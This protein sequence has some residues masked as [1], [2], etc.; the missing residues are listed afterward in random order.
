M[1][2]STLYW[3]M[4]MVGYCSPTLACEIRG[5]SLMSS[6]T[7]AVVT[8]ETES[9]DIEITVDLLHAPRTGCNFLKYVTAGTYDGG[10]FGRT[11]RPDNQQTTEVPISVIQGY[12]NAK[13]NPDGFG[14]LALE[15]T[16]D[17]GLLHLDGT[18]SMARAAQDDATSQFF[19]CIGKQPELDY[20]GRRHPDRQ[21]FAAFAKVSHGMD[22]VRRIHASR[23]QGE[24]LAPSILIRS[25]R[26]MNAGR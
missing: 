3:M 21:G 13:R 14:A 10:N 24:S 15:R 2:K 6:A 11:V 8:M 1:S 26:L 9:G 23:A 16:R 25:A 7:E 17:T 22:V 12:P 19:I 20:G 4:L 18:V 5:V